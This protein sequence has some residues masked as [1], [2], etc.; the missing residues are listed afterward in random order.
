MSFD[1]N[2]FPADSDRHAIWEMLVRN[3]I[4]RRVVLPAILPTL[5]AVSPDDRKFDREWPRSG[6][7]AN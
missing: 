1:V 5:L 6:S 4:L 7:G 2:P 3:T